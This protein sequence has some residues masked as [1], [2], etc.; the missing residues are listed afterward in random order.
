MQR[1]F[2]KDS[3]STRYILCTAHVVTYHSCTEFY[4]NGHTAFEREECV[5]MISAHLPDDPLRR[6]S[7]EGKLTRKDLKHNGPEERRKRTKD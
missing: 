2:P 4:L 5:S 7:M 1:A 3:T 6:H